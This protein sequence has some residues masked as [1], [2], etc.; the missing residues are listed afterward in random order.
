VFLNFLPCL[1]C[2][3]YPI[4]THHFKI[5]RLLAANSLS[6]TTTIYEVDMP[7]INH[8]F[9]LQLL[10]AADQ[11]AGIPAL[12]DAPR[13]SAV[14]NALKN[15]DADGDGN[16][17][18]VN[19]L[20]LSSGD[21][22]I[23]SPFFSASET[24]FGTP[25]RA[26]IL[27]QNE[28]GFQ[29]IAFGNHE[30]DFGTSTI[31]NLLEVD[32][33]TAYPG[34]L[35]P[36]LSA[37]LDFTTD[38]NL[39]PFVTPDGQE[40]S[41]ISNSIAGN[42][43][44]P[45]NGERIGVI[46]ATT[47]TLASISSP[48]EVTIRP[49]EF[50][51]SD[52]EAIAALATEI[53]ASVNQLLAD[54]P[55]INKVVL[56]AHMQQLSIEEQLAELLTNV[57]IIVAGGS[58][59]LLADE[60]DP[61]RAGDE[62]EGVYPL[63]KT[64]AD[65]NPIAVVNTDGNYKYVGRLVVDFDENGIIIPESIDPNI[66][67]AYATDA[68]GVAAVNG[69]PDPEI[70]EITNQLQEVIAAQE[71]NIF[72]S[73][74]VFLNGTR[75]DVRTQETNLGNLSADANL[76]YARQFDEEVVISLKNGGGIRDDIGEII[77]PPGSTSP[78][79]FIKTPPQ[80]NE[81]AGKEEGDISQLDIANSLRFNNGLTL[82]TVTAEEL[83]E[84]IEH[85]ISAT[86]DGATPGQFPQVAGIA[87]SFDDDLPAGD[88]IQSLAIKDSEDNIIDIVAENGQLVGDSN[89]T[90]RIVTL[91]FLADGGDGYPFPDRDRVDLAQPE[92]ATRT[93]VATFAEDGSEQDILAEYLVANFR[94]TPFTQEDTSF[95]EDERIQ[96]LDFRQDTVLNGDSS[97]GDDGEVAIYDIQGEGHLSPFAGELVKTKGI[98]GNSNRGTINISPDDF[99]PERIQIQ[100][101]SGILP[102]F[103]VDVNV[104]DR[105]GNVTGVLGYNFGNY[106]VNVTETFIPTSA[107][108]KAET[109][110]L[111]GS[112]RQLTVA[113]Y[114]VL[115]LDPNDN[116]GDKDVADGRFE[117]IAAHIVNNLNQPDII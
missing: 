2:P 81:L 35:F 104:G 9:T 66:S 7:D 43:I 116:D 78:D 68:E 13:F 101:D 25:G 40:A 76:N 53:Q 89:R 60:T 84:I 69:T 79:D 26:D 38:E 8:T 85:G 28:L 58:N 16:L 71:G 63:L 49:L 112:D 94:E 107:N 11:E 64:A 27:I 1:P 61:L 109:T 19:T 30:F 41:T 10:H 50:N 62:V 114:N 31:A 90:F 80:A 32:P 5:D 67:G 4:S 39:A 111:V 77:V 73:S 70:V 24:V 113:S 96:N 97:N 22:Y 117:A 23:P 54:N 46:G 44:I 21:A 51:S 99:N 75:G 56:L 102:D 3:P 88:R 108:L 106:E 74:D 95:E 29:A 83:L 6:G 65:G 48:G 18:Y 98:G 72:G 115:N 52:P 34:A 14:L 45:V 82:L 86:E 55:D 37:N 17:D 47:P 42:T 87:F 105:L 20:I 36:Y 92:T 91:S 110:N 100:F 103:S 93:G 59:T 15:Q 12:E 57:D 33:E